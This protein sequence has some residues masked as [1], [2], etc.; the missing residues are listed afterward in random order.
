MFCAA[1]AANLCASCDVKLHSANKLASRHVRTAIGKG[2]DVYGTC[3]IHSEKVV[4]FFCSECHTPVCVY[5]KMVG[6]HS[7]GEN[8][9]HKL[10]PVAEA[11]ETVLRE[12]DIVSP[13]AMKTGT[14]TNWSQY[15][16]ILAYKTG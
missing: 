4:E 3:R 7:T 16:L 12:I 10:V 11:Y 15:S 13:N 2:T 5:C 9:K 6:H 8:A 1:D 14:R